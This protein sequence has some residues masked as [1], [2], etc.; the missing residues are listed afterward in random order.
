[1]DAGHVVLVNLAGG[2]QI[3]ETEGDLLGRLFLRAILYHAKRR[4]NNRP[5]FVWMDEG[6][7]YLSGDVPVLFEE[8]RKHSVGI[9]IA[10]QDLSQLGQPGDRVR[11]AVLAVPQ[12]RMLFRLNSVAE[13]TLLAP[14]VVKLNLE[15]PVHLLVKPTVVGDQ[16]VTLQNG[17]T[18]TST[19]TTD[20]LGTGMTDSAA[21]TDTLGENWGTAHTKGVTVTEGRSVARGAAETTG[22]TRSVTTTVGGAETDTDT[23][24]QSRTSSRGGSHSD[25][26]SFSD[27]DGESTSYIRSADPASAEW[28]D[29]TDS[30]DSSSGRGRAS[31]DTASWS[32]ADSYSTGHSHASTSSWSR[33][34]GVAHSQSN[35]KSRTV[36][37][38]HSRA[39]TKATTKSRGGSRSHATTKGRAV[40]NNA[41]HAI[42]HGSGQSAGW[43]EAYRALYADLPTA[44][45]SKE[46][47][48]HMAAEVINNL[49]TG[50]AIVKALVGN[51]IE[52]AMVRLPRIDDP[53]GTPQRQ[54]QVR[55][56]LLA[57]SPF[58]LPAA[59]A[60]KIIEDR[61]EWL[62]AQGAKLLVPPAEPK[63]YRQPLK[64]KSKR[65]P[66]QQQDGGANGSKPQKGDNHD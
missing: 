18:S 62:K 41:S 56:E 15:M 55:T 39:D 59:E 31:S 57:K 3:Y 46:N 1:M 33:A 24:S 12:T 6:H 65:A 23:A 29:R 14:E 63:T 58:A 19:G 54:Q 44:V 60:T 51:R 20:T 36:T 2:T 45:H 64:A 16:L 7:R 49:P 22:T 61:R 48:V 35:T 50:T 38:S 43:G 42:S 13:A 8:V 11:E 25:D 34:E 30:R 28:G 4:T 53:S 5:C 66:K 47:V 37:D 9:I 17:A 52:S 10:H 27:S 26:K 21:E 40:T 32:E